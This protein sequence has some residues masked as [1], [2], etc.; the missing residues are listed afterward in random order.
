MKTSEFYGISVYAKDKI[1]TVTLE[2]R[3]NGELVTL[4]MCVFDG[5]F[6]GGVGRFRRQTCQDHQEVVQGDEMDV[7]LHVP[8]W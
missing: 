5:N 8:G 6:E 7:N 4:H 3:E 2:Y 1:D